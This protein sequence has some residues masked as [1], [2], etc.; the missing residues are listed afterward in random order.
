VSVL[1]KHVS[2]FLVEVCKQIG[3]KQIHTDISYELQGHIDELMIEYIQN[4]MSE[5]EA[6]EKAVRQMGDPVRIGRQLHKTHRPK[7]EW[8]IIAL[9]GVMVLIGGFALFSIAND[10][11][12]LMSVDKFSKSYLAY[13]II[14]IGIFVTCYF[15]DYTKLEKYS[16]HIFMTTLAFLYGS[17]WLSNTVNGNLYMTIGGFTFSQVN[18]VTPFFLISF[19]GLLNKWAH[20]DVK[21]MLK[22]LGLALVAVFMC[23]LVQLSFA[24]AILLGLGFLVMITTAIMSK[25]FK[26]KRKSYLL[27]IYSCVISVFLLLLVY[28]INSKHYRLK[29]FLAFLNRKSDPMGVGYI[30]NVLRKVLASAKLFG[31]GDGL[32][33]NYQGIYKL[34]LPEAHTD[35]IFTYIVSSFGWALGVLLIAVM[36]LTIIRMFLATRD[37]RSAYGKYVANSVVT[38]FALQA[39]A[40]I[41]MNMGF[42]PVMGISLPFISYGGSNFVMNMALI[43]LLLG[44]YRRKDLVVSCSMASILTK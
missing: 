35:F 42:F 40:S 19:S 39:I 2:D 36:A 12:S 13:T 27:S 44:I 17:Q 4:G 15:F 31:R 21:N 9:V 5:D 20:D 32:Y 28:A 43:G 38:V 6:A 24:S 14:G 22:L 16:L 33:A 37:I 10:K 7:A 3:Y 18:I 23:M 8:S 25:N 29:R 11:A 41:L 30:Y 1:N 34:A 26:G